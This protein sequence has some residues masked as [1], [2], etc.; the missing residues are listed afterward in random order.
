MKKL[1]VVI[2]VVLAI[3][4]VAQAGYTSGGCS[5]RVYVTYS[6]AKFTF[7]HGWSSGSSRT[8]SGSCS[9]SNCNYSG[10]YGWASG[11]VEYYIGRGGGTN[12]G[13]YSACGG[14]STLY[15]NSCNG[16]NLTGSGSFKQ[17]N[18]SSGCGNMGDHQNGW[19]K[20]GKG[21]SMS[22]G[23][24]VVGVENWS[25]GSGS[26]NCQA[27]GGNWY[28]LWWGQGS[29][30]ASCGSS[31][32]TS[33]TTTSGSSTSTT[34]TSGSSTSTTT[35]GGGSG[36]WVVRARSTDGKGQLSCKGTTWTLGTGMSNKTI[37]TSD[38]SGT[39]CF[40]NDASGRDVQVDYVVVQGSTKQAESQ[41]YN[42]GVWQNGKCGGSYSEWLH[43]NGCIGF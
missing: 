28:T 2:A 33:T 10:I 39:V 8:V 35:S 37:S 4:A 14:S 19:S 29:A 34:T 9:C 41:S 11:P 13:T 7:G 23:Y 15:T 26:A 3:S 6:N 16:P 27:S 36:T 32:S 31:G 22:G 12:C 40:N 5:N 38:Q 24:Q 18:C 25:G 21:A 1:I 20:L 43:C 17:Y 42:S 30:S